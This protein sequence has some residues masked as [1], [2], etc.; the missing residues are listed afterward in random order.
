MYVCDLDNSR[1]AQVLSILVEGISIR[2][3]VRV[4]GAAKKTIAKLFG[5][6]GSLARETRQWTRMSPGTGRGDNSPPV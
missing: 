3:T 6:I 4:T 2:T 5:A 1:R